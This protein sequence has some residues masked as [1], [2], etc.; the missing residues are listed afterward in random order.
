LAS[1]SKRS[2]AVSRLDDLELARFAIARSAGL[3]GSPLFVLATTESTNDDAKRAARAENA[4]P[5]GATWVAD[6]QSAGRG[7]QGRAWLATSGESLLFSV[8]LRIACLPARVPLMALGA[9]LAVRD[10]VAANCRDDVVRIKWPNDVV[11]EDRKVAG[12]LVESSMSGTSVAF[13]VVGIGLNVGARALSPELETQ[14]T[15]V[16]RLCA[17]SEPPSRGALLADI[18]ARLEAILPVVAAR[19]LTPFH[20]RLEAADALRGRQ[21]KSESGEGRAAGI[22]RDGRLVVAMADGTTA[23]WNAG[24]VHLRRA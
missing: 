13:V 14:A 23:R 19:G 16:A 21:V 1:T 8:L 20:A 10:A 3:L 17:P 5:H 24:E 2:R 12:I 7:R 6:V 11:A 9:G 15:S 4:A 18:L 22:D